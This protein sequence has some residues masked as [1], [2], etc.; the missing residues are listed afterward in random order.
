MVLAGD[1]NSAG[2]LVISG[3]FWR[4]LGSDRKKDG[5]TAFIVKSIKRTRK[6]GERRIGGAREKENALDFLVA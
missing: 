3:W 5:A 2:A 4:V 6:E 1:N